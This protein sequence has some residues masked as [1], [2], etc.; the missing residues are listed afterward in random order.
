[1]TQHVRRM[2]EVERVVAGERKV[3]Q[4]A[5]TTGH[6]SHPCCAALLPGRGSLHCT[7]LQ[8]Y[9]AHLGMRWAA[10]TECRPVTRPAAAAAAT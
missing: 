10:G 1:M 2:S 8:P 5:T 3:Q 6:I 9:T 4:A 7:P